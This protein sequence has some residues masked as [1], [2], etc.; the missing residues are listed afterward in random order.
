MASRRA[1]GHIE[2]SSVPYHLQRGSGISGSGG[3]AMIK[4][5]KHYLI[6]YP[7][8][9]DYGQTIICL[10]FPSR[11]RATASGRY[12]QFYFNEHVPY[13]QKINFEDTI[14]SD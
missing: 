6:N 9:N 7:Y 10:S 8:L 13:P 5:L 2:P 14:R 11:D 3:D 12:E 1:N 4:T